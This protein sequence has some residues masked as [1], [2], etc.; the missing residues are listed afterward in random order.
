LR[1]LLH[2]D[3]VDGPEPWIQL[4]PQQGTPAE[5]DGAALEAYGPGDLESIWPGILV[6]E[7]GTV[8]Q[9]EL[10]VVPGEVGTQS[11]VEAFA[12]PA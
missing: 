6:R 3:E 7:R 8:E 1:R 4:L 9:Q 2:D 10:D 12:V 11:V 5:R